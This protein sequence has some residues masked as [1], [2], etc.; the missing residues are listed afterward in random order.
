MGFGEFQEKWKSVLAPGML[1]DFVILSDDIFPIDPV[2]IA[3]VKV[4]TTLA[5]GRV[6]FEAK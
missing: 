2:K 5:D 1:A 4:L 6:V 3:E